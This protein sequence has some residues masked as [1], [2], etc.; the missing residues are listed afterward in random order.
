MKRKSK[1]HQKGVIL[2]LIGLVSLII[3][4]C[5]DNKK[6]E[7]KDDLTISYNIKTVS[8]ERI[9][10]ENEKIDLILKEYE[11]K[12]VFYANTFC[13]TKFNR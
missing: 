11:E 1:S 13:K 7:D 3:L 12:I 9:R 5:L 10:T 4:F 8:N 6:M 2:V